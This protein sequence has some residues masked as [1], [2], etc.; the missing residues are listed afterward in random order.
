[1]N[2]LSKILL[3]N[4]YKNLLEATPPAAPPDDNGEIN[5]TDDL[6]ERIRRQT[7]T[8][9]DPNRQQAIDKL[10][11]LLR[12]L[13]GWDSSHLPQD[14]REY[15]IQKILSGQPPTIDEIRPFLPGN[16]SE[17][18]LSK[19]LQ[20][21]IIF[22]AIVA[23]GPGAASLGQ[24]LAARGGLWRIFEILGYIWEG[25]AG[26]YEGQDDIE[27]IM[28]TIQNYDYLRDLLLFRES[29]TGPLRDLLDRL[30]RQI[31]DPRQNFLTREEI[32]ELNREFGRQV[33]PLGDLYRNTPSYSP[34][35][36][37]DPFPIF[38]P[39]RKPILTPTNPNIDQQNLD[40]F[41]S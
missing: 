27:D 30:L 8:R 31:F 28:D 1:M 4:Y 16:T 39:F 10:D 5:P 41:H 17:E 21:M 40:Q 25:A 34:V 24:M 26:G 12:Q 35:P 7:L 36:V 14:I 15:L 33:K 37:E 9:Q 19:M 29:A 18:A 20:F 38:N 22:I 2:N 3:E 23:S 6:W 32:E 13:Y 11:E